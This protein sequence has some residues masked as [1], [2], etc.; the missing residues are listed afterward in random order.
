[1]RHTFS[2]LAIIGLTAVLTSGCAGPEKK[3]GRGVSNSM[4]F[5]RMGEIRKSLEQDA[6]FN[7]GHTSYATSFLRGFNSTLARTCMGVYEIATFPIP[8][9]DP[10]ATTVVKPG[11]VW[12]DN[13]RPRLPAGP[14]FA[15]DTFVGFSGGDV[16]PGIPGSR[17]RIFDN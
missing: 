10:V 11:T 6:L 5:A 17:F 7:D 2:L 15:T 16:A 13:Y 3:L 8:P 1:M 9:Y 12:P 4:E 14:I